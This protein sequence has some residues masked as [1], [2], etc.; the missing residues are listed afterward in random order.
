MNLRSPLKKRVVD[1]PGINEEELAYLKETFQ[2]F[3]IDN[4]G[5]VSVGE[6]LSSI[7]ALGMEEANPLLFKIIARMSEREEYQEGM[8]FEQFVNAFTVDLVV[9]EPREHMESLFM[10]LTGGE[11]GEED[12]QGIGVEGI[13]RIVKN[14]GETITVDE[15]KDMLKRLASNG[16]ELSFEDFT[17]IMTRKVYA[18]SAAA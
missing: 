16:H 5:L 10:L 2:L 18:T 14:V 6:F 11:G 12:S 17:E 4:S 3:D 9:A 13:K 15:I 8:S 7:Q 1:R